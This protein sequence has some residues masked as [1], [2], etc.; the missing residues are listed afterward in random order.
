MR[1]F[2]DIGSAPYEGRCAQLGRDDYW[3]RARRECRAFINQLRRVFGPEPEGAR[4]SI[5]S[6]PHDFGTYLSVICSYES[7]NEAAVDYAFRCEGEGP[8]EWDEEASASLRKGRCGNG[9]L[10]HTVSVCHTNR[11]IRFVTPIVRGATM[12]TAFGLGLVMVSSRACGHFQPHEIDKAIQRHVSLDAHYLDQDEEE[13]NLNAVEHGGEVWSRSIHGAGRQLWVTTA[14][15]HSR[16]ILV[17]PGENA[18]NVD[19][20]KYPIRVSIT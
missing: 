16:T 10:A 7:E 3:E 15:D 20:E 4:L 13:A 5:K 8:G 6:N 14:P 2:I 11:G 18:N 12:N 1:D 9:L 17:L 19:L